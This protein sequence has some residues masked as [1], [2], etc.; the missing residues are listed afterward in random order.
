MIRSELQRRTEQMIATASS[1]LKRAFPRIAA[2]AAL[3]LAN[4]AG[5]SPQPVATVQPQDPFM[6]CTAIVAEV[7]SNN[8]KVQEL[9]SEK[10]LKT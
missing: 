5:R 7:Q 1:G 3:V 6:D 9:A 4:F 10:G 8:Q 2:L